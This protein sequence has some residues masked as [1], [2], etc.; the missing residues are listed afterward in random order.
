MRDAS[1]GDYLL[2]NDKPAKII[3]ESSSRQVIIELLED[4]KCP[5]CD[6]AIGKEQISVI[7]SSPLY[8][9]NAKPMQTI[10][11]DDTLWI[12]NQNIVNKQKWNKKK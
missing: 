11:D 12:D 9:E 4:R 10:R 1:L 3:G 8:Q 7:V 5:H 6:E 2:W